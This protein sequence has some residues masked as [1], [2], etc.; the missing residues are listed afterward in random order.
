MVNKIV[1][2]LKKLKEK[3]KISD[4][5]YNSYILSLYNSP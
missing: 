4:E 2:F 3:Q 5:V 1:D